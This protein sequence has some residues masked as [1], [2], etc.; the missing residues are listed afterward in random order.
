[1]WKAPAQIAKTQIGAQLVSEPQGRDCFSSN[2]IFTPIPMSWSDK[3]S[4]T[5]KLHSSWV[6][7]IIFDR[8]FQREI[9]VL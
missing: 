4:A 7:K 3:W 8:D 6:H 1:M 5:S 2:A 9:P